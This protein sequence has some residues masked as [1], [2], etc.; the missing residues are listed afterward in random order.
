MTSEAV[1]PSQPIHIAVVGCGRWGP[2]H[3]RCL[4]RIPGCTVTAVD[5]DAARLDAI[6]SEFPAVQT[7]DDPLRVFDDQGI[8]AVVIATPTATHHGL[9]RDALQA[10]KHI[11]CEKPLCRTSREA[12]ELVELAD[13]KNRTLMTG[14]I[15]LF[16]PGIRN[17]KELSD[18]G[19]LG[20]IQY[21]S[22]VRTN[23]GPIRSDVNASFD[24]ASH[25]ISIFNWILG[26]VPTS[27]SATGGAF[28]QSNVHDVVFA[29]LVYPSGQV[30]SIHAS[31]LN[32]KKVRQITVVGSERMA[33]WDDMQLGTP[34]AIY[35]RG[36][37]AAKEPTDFGERLRVSMW[38]GDVRLPK[39]DPVEPLKMQG[40]YFHDAILSGQL[41]LSDGPFSLGVV[42]VL[43]AI[44]LSLQQGGA[45]VATE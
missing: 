24:L 21:L 35:D 31:W 34:V 16:N 5:R 43:E 37:N 25:D 44:D 7:T 20:I 12:N 45:R 33:T 14:H 40:Q 2:N 26:A 4:S 36:A 28:V 41:G 17:I 18:G 13:A 32:P 38:D 39:I 42:K 3:V 30:A 23:L 19:E 15:F 11:L 27:V 10:S 8:D 29:N 9:C 1:A 22:A 6:R